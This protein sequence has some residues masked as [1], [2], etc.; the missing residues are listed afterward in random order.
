MPQLR[1]ATRGSALAR[2][3][4]DFVAQALRGLD[5]S[6]DVR[7]VVVRTAGDQDQTTRLDAFGETGVFTRAVQAAMLNGEADLA[8]HSLKDLQTQPTDGLTLAAIPARASRRDVVVTA[9]RKPLVALDALSQAAVVATGS[10]RRKAQLLY[11]RP[12]LKIVEIR[13]NVGTRLDKMDNGHCDAMILA[14]A[15]L[16]RLGLDDRIALPLPPDSFLPAAGQGAL[17]IECRVDDQSTAS[18]ISKMNDHRTS[19]EVTAERTVLSELR[20]GCH[21]PLGV[22]ACFKGKSNLRVDAVLFDPQGHRRSRVS[23]TGSADQ[24]AALGIRVAE[25]LTAAHDGMQQE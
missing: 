10:P 8:V 12:D 9:N 22:Y 20:A 7:V 13:G 3:Q 24:A 6:C 5:N 17:G 23:E 19:I 15:G 2:W 21:A 4:A 18:L 16:R 11:R 25:S 1:I 14:E